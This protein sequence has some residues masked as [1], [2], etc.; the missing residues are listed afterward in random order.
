MT[1]HFYFAITI[2]MLSGEIQILNNDHPSMSLPDIRKKPSLEQ[3]KV[4]I[5]ETNALNVLKPNFGY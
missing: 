1:L 4:R 3:L 2:T 5:E